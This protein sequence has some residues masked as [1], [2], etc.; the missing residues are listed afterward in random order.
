MSWT[1]AMPATSLEMIALAAPP[2]SSAILDIGGGTS[3]LARELLKAGYTDIT[4]ADISGAAIE[5]ARAALSVEADRIFWV[6]S[7]VRT[8]EFGRRFDLWH[9][10]AVFHFMVET[11]DRNAYLAALERSLRPGGHLVLATFGPEGPT[12]CSELPVARYDAVAVSSVLGPGYELL[13]SRL[14]DHRTPSGRTQQFTY[15]LLRRAGPR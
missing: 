13:S 15:A 9:D 11:E 14:V 8:H 12:E 10:R 7:D 5:R 4:V 2:R 6:Q 1:E 3:G